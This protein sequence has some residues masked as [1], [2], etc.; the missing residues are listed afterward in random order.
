MKKRIII[1]SRAEKELKKFSEKVQ[2]EFEGFIRILKTQGKIGF[3]EGKKIGRNLFEIRVK[4]GG[5]YRGFYAYIGKEGILILHFFRKKS[6]K[7][8][9]KNIKVAERRLREYEL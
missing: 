2:L 1:D 6:Q 3:P 4:T 7:T 5:A 9:L 8:P